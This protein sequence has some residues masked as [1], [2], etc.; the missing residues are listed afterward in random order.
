VIIYQNVHVGK[1]IQATYSN[2]RTIHMLA[3]GQSP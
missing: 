1:I 2:G 3:M